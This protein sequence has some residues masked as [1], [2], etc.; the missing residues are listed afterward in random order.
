MLTYQANFFSYLSQRTNFYIRMFVEFF[1]S[2]KKNSYSLGL[3]TYFS[4]Y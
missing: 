3:I 4:N 2:E 1:S